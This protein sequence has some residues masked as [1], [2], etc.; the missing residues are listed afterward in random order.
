MNK[1]AENLKYK[2]KVISCYAVWKSF[3]INNA[4]I[5]IKKW[6]KE[7]EGKCSSQLKT[8]STWETIARWSDETNMLLVILK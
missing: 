6:N 5:L 3:N 1:M 2:M 7:T 4:Y 8:T